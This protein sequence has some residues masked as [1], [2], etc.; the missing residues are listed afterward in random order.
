MNFLAYHDLYREYISVF[1]IK[2]SIRG[3]MYLFKR[4]YKGNI[5]WLPSLLWL[6]IWFLFLTASIGTPVAFIWPSRQSIPSTRPSHSWAFAAVRAGHETPVAINS[7]R[8]KRTLT[9]GKDCLSQIRAAK[10]VTGDAVPQM[11]DTDEL[12]KGLSDSEHDLKCVTVAF[13]PYHLPVNKTLYNAQINIGRTIPTVDIRFK[14]RT[15]S[16]SIWSWNKVSSLFLKR[17]KWGMSSKQSPS[18]EKP[19]IYKDLWIKGKE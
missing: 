13:P 6:L 8:G 17:G 3:H 10:T 11:H 14:R 5:L 18:P 19:L 16:R 7:S 1:Q 12:Q 4:V 15:S 2:S 9:V